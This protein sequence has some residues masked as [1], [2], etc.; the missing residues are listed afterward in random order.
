MSKVVT[1]PKLEDRTER[2]DL[3][4][5]FQG[6]K[7]NGKV[8]LRRCVPMGVMR[9]ERT[10]MKV[11]EGGT[12]ISIQ[13]HSEKNSNMIFDKQANETTPKTM[14][15]ILASPC[16]TCPLTATIT[17]LDA[18]KSNTLTLFYSEV[19]QSI[20]LVPTHTPGNTE[21]HHLLRM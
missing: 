20:S 21:C 9:Y 2:G 15:L 11:V 3:I 4:A 5:V 6:L 7:R 13:K 10:W 8:G 1:P 19:Q 17:A 12:L 14:T 18:I 16:M